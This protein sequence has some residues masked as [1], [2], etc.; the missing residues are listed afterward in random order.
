MRKQKFAPAVTAAVVASAVIAPPAQAAEN[1]MVFSDLCEVHLA[2][3]KTW[4]MRPHEAEA[5]LKKY[6]GG[7]SYE[8]ENWYKPA[9]DDFRAVR[10]CANG[11]P[12]PQPASQNVAPNGATPNSKQ[13]DVDTGVVIG[14]IVGVLASLALIGGLA[15]QFVPG[16]R[17][18]LPF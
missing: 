7:K 6:E 14:I 18:M 3:G 4:S 9:P 16:I 13:A 2:G 10:A 11:K 8:F 15:Y 17:E 5:W 1:V 12:Y